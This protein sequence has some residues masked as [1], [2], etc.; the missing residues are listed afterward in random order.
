MRFDFSEAPLRHEAFSEKPMSFIDQAP[1]NLLAA[2]IDVV[3]IETGAR[4]AR[5]R[6]QQKQLENLLRHAVARSPFW[7]NRIGTKKITDIRLSDLPILS[8][9]DLSNQVASEGSLLAHDGAVR[10]VKHATSGSSGRPVEFFVSEM[11]QQYTYV[12]STAQFFIEGLDLSFNRTHL[13]TVY[14]RMK[15]G[16]IAEKI[17]GWLGPLNAV[18]KTGSNKE[19]AYLRPNR[20]ALLEELAKDSIGY[21]ISAPRLIETL[22]YDHDV[23]FLSDHGTKLFIPIA[24]RTSK[25]LRDKFAAVGIPVRSNYS[26]EEI[27]YIGAE[28]VHH[29]DIYHVAESNVIIEIDHGDNVLVHGNRLGRVL[30]THLHSYATPLVRYDIGDF[31]MLSAACRCGHNGPALSSVYGRQ[32]SLIKRRDG[33]IVPF[34]LNAPYLL[35]IIRCDEYRIRQTESGTLDVEIGGVKY[36]DS[37]QTN[38]LSKFFNLLAGDEFEIRIKAVREIDWGS[39]KKRLGFRSELV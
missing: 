2:I 38:A 30:V 26:S 39:D 13:R 4:E 19:I 37:D 6:W 17:P 27:G 34:I 23:S 21:L 1:K 22:F 5:E 24:E 9:S 8:R 14:D 20:D 16:F 28:C 36:L 15:S 3:A 25:N 31:A 35:K 12:R 32:K 18:F 10:A 7:R 11:N 33:T 29:P